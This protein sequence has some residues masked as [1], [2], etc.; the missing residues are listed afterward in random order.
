M[1]KEQCVRCGKEM[2]HKVDNTFWFCNDGGEHPDYLIS[3]KF[4]YE[5]I[6]NV[7]LE[8]AR[9]NRHPVGKHEA[10]D[11]TGL[12]TSNSGRPVEGEGEG[13]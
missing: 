8:Q 2:V 12:P 11:G 13:S 3:T 1:M 9:R 4:S 6:G 5:N 7:S 10:T